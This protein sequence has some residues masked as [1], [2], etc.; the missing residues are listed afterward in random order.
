MTMRNPNVRYLDDEIYPN[1]Y[2]RR[3]KAARL[4]EAEEFIGGAILLAALAV[5]EH[6]FEFAGIVEEHQHHGGDVAHRRKIH[7]VGA[8]MV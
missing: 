4:H 7:V 1:L 6:K 3:A 5:C 2:R 8:K